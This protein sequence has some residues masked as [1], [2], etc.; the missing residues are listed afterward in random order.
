MAI[1]FLDLP[2]FDAVSPANEGAWLTLLDVNGNP[3]KRK[4]KLL[5]T[6]SDVWRKGNY[7]ESNLRQKAL[8]KTGKPHNPSA[9]ETEELIRKR[10]VE[11]TVAWEGFPD[12]SGG[13]AP[14]TAENVHALYSDARVGPHIFAQALDFVLD[15]A[16]FG[17]GGEKEA[18]PLDP[19]ARMQEVAG[20]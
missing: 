7:K 11:V 18:N 19:S 12:G 8:Q 9:E 17:Q 15:P 13:D 4:L 3:T 16:N 14:C 2:E 5:G 10:L 1:N 20:N 6:N